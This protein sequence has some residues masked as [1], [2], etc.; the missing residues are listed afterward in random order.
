LKDNGWEAAVANWK[1]KLTKAVYVSYDLPEKVVYESPTVE[2][3]GA[4]GKKEFI[5]KINN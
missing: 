5:F 2:K 4:A 3:L 1:N